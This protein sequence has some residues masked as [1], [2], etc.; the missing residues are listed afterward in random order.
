E[1][2]D[3]LMQSGSHSDQTAEY[4]LVARI[5]DNASQFLS[6]FQAVEAR[7]QKAV[8][9]VRRA[10]GQTAPIEL[11]ADEAGG[12][13]KAWELGLEEIAVQTVIQLDGDVVHRVQPK[14]AGTS[15]GPLLA[16]HQSATQTAVAYWKTLIDL[17]GDLLGGAVRM[18]GLRS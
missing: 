8:P 5:R 15:S 4:W 6:I 17:I 16:I 12:V 18:L 10:Q 11:L 14:Y 9:D 7:E 1:V 2:L 13:R 3:E